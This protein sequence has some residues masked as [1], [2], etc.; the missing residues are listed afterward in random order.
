MKNIELINQLLDTTKQY[1]NYSCF[2]EEISINDKIYTIDYQNISP[3]S[4]HSILTITSS[5]KR[6]IIINISNKKSCISYLFGKN[7]ITNVLK[8]QQDNSYIISST[9]FND[10]PYSNDHCL[11]LLEKFYYIIAINDDDL[12]YINN[13]LHTKLNSCNSLKRGLKK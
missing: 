6:K 3:T 1:H 13:Y 5:S 12:Y 8:K 11:H 4:C 9:K 2:H 10:I 7:K